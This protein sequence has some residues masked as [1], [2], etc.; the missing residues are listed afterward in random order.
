MYDLNEE[1]YERIAE[2]YELDTGDDLRGKVK[3]C[4]RRAKLK[5]YTDAFGWYFVQ[6]GIPVRHAT[7][8]LGLE[9][10]LTKPELAVLDFNEELK[11]GS[12]KGIEEVLK[13]LTVLSNR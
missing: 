5:K 10:E 7:F 8:I 9:R 12:G 6:E 2:I 4:Q 1:Q 13:G 3:T 11:R